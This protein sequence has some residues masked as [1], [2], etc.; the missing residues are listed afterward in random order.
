MSAPT[1][2]K[3]LPPGST[4][5][6][7]GG[8]QLGRMAALAAA[9]M[10]YHTHIY[11]PDRDSPASHV[12]TRSTVAAYDDA[13]QL[14]AFAQ[15]VDVVTFEFENIPVA[16]V[17]VLAALV[18]VRP[19]ARVLAVG[20][21]RISEKTFFNGLGIATAP[22]RAVTC[23]ADLE[24]AVAE[25][26]RPSVLKTARMGYDGKGQVKITAETDLTAAWDLLQTDHAVLEGFVTFTGEISV[27][28]ARGPDGVSRTFE[29]VWNVHTNH[30]LDT[31]T[32]PAP[33][34]AQQYQTALA[35]AEKSA[36]AL[37]LVGLLAVELFLADTGEILANEMAPRPHNSGHW[38]IDACI[39]DQFE[40]F[41]RAVCGL[42]L[43]NPD[44]HSDA[45][46]TNLIGT[47]IDRWPDILVDPNAKLHLY[48]KAEAREGRKMGHVTTIKPR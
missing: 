36:Q 5:G 24:R 48:G 10:G 23:L 29:P 9:R 15:A 6:I 31:S 7:I 14:T 17:E 41:I 3:P 42:P 32:V 45:V 21:D 33:I 8:G 44:R 12:A 28:I 13:A 34:T 46:M 26:G 43:G 20:Q 4:I 35:I 47:D 11:C 27:I 40:Q 18:T 25:L 1:Q 22:W 37:D 16:S 39:T 19:S 2:S 30:I 38:T